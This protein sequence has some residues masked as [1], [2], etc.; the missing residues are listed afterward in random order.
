[1]QVAGVSSMEQEGAA[2]KALCSVRQAP[3]GDAS[4]FATQAGLDGG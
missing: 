3:G 1:M 4:G 2:R